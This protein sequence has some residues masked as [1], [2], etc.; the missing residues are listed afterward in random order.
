MGSQPNSGDYLQMPPKF[1]GPP[2]NVG[3]KKN[4][5]DH[6]FRDFHTWHRISSERNVAWTNH[7]PSV[8]LQCVLQK[9]TYFQWPLTQK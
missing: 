2:S 6:F 7:N 5:L 1:P 8:N 4:I 9:L 3:S